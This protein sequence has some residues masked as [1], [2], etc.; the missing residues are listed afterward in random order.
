MAKTMHVNVPCRIKAIGV[1]GGGCNALNRM[2][3][4]RIQGVEFT[5]ANTDVQALLIWSL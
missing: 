4:A 5:A 3:K 2:V 1:G